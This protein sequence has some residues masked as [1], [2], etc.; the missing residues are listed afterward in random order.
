MCSLTTPRITYDLLRPS[1]PR[2]TKLRPPILRFWHLI[3][4]LANRI[5]LQDLFVVLP[6]PLITSPRT[7]FGPTGLD[8]CGVNYPMGERSPEK[9]NNLSCHPSACGTLLHLFWPDIWVGTPRYT[10]SSACSY[11]VVPDMSIVLLSLA[12]RPYAK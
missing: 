6:V 4:P 1:F 8:V 7:G 5:C 9:G 2:F 11:I 10:G 12:F 3:R